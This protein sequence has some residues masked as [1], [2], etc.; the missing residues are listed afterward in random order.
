MRAKK[1]S[2]K[3]LGFSL[4]KKRIKGEYY[5]Y[6]ARRIKGKV[7]TVYI[8]RDNLD[9]N[10]EDIEAKLTAWLKEHHPDL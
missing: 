2:D 1:R 8:G 3:Y 10:Q 6:A 9:I 7:K 5:V 4:T